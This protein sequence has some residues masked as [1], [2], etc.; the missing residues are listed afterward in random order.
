MVAHIFLNHLCDG[1]RSVHVDNDNKVFL[2]H[3]CDGEHLKS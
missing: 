3:L 1:E 2:N